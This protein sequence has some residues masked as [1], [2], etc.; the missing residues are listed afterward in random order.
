MM[1]SRATVLRNTY[2][3]GIIRDKKKNQLQMVAHSLQE[4]NQNGC[5]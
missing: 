3:N 4:K 1:R 5:H 2:K